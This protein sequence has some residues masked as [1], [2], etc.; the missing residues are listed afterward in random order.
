MHYELRPYQVEAVE[1]G[2]W[3]LR[4][5]GK[6]F[7]IQ[8]ATGAGKSLIIADICHK[9]DE[10]V[11]VLQPS[12]ELLEQN[13]AKL[14]SYGV[15]DIAIY[16]ASLK[17]KE[18]AKFTYATIGSIYKKPE[19]FKHFKY[20][21]IDECHDVNPKNLDGMY[22]SFLDAIGCK[23]VLGLTATPYRIVQK[24]TVYQGDQYYTASLRMINR[25]APFFFK[26]I[27]Y[28]IETEE[29]QKMGYLAPI[30]YH[31][32]KVAL[33]RL[34]VNTTGADF[35]TKS[36]NGWAMTKVERIASVIEGIDQKVQRNLVFCSSV[37]QAEAVCERLDARG[38]ESHLITGKTADKRREQLVADFRA[39]KYKHLLNVGVFTKGFDVPELDCIILAR[40][41]M[42]VALY[43]QM[44]G[45]GVRIDPNNPN[46]VLRVVDLA[47]VVKRLGRVESI[48]LGRE[49]HKTIPNFYMDMVESE[50]GRLDETVLFHFKV[51]RNIFGRNLEHDRVEQ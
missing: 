8:A 34:V 45:R 32:D 21:I 51:E 28:S 35:T 9:L 5:T 46:K 30:R 15:Q 10:P 19:L 41:T 37:A 42:S 22:K 24:F 3:H 23:H 25:I 7:V 36:L 2:M 38:I 18:I 39:G 29:L 31:T 49:P 33:D 26:S 4:N 48:K 44:V 17:S 12:R 20:V 11:L 6:P 47:G 27:V 13:Y 43:Y 16:S 40:P 50:V 14:V 1:V